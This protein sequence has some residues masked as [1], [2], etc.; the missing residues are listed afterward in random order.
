MTLAFTSSQVSAQVYPA[1]WPSDTQIG[2]EGEWQAYTFLSSAIGDQIGNLDLSNGG[3]T[4]Q[5]ATDISGFP[6]SESAYIAYDSVNDVLFFRF[7]IKDEPLASGVG[8]NGN[9]GSSNGFNASGPWASGSWS[10]TLDANGDGFLDTAILIDG[11]SG[12]TGDIDSNAGG[13]LTSGGQP[14]QFGTPMGGGDDLLIYFNSDTPNNQGLIAPTV[15]GGQVSAAG[16]LVWVGETQ[17]QVV[18]GDGQNGGTILDGFAW[19][20]GTTRASVY[21][22]DP[23]VADA[24][25]NPEV[26]G[27]LNEDFWGDGWFIDVQVPRSAII[28]D[29]GEEL[30]F[31]DRPLLIGF[32]TANSNFD[33][34]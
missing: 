14:V 5:S 7:R 27:G 21:S 17:R 19:D 23:A 3:T 29:L 15:S 34:Y 20:F 22:S 33:L 4:P 31:L 1:P 12:G 32:S 24:P 16:E 9:S 30:L 2:G 18:G 8:K 10:I 6:N 26:G 11:N 13:A 25:G 28:N